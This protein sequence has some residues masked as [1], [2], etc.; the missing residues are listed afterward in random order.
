MDHPSPSPPRLHKSML[1]SNCWI[2]FWLLLPSSCNKR[3]YNHF[4]NF[5]LTIIFW[6]T[7][8]HLLNNPTLLIFLE[9]FVT[10]HTRP[11][12][13]IKIDQKIMHSN[14]PSWEKS[15][16]LILSASIFNPLLPVCQ[17]TAITKIDLRH[18]VKYLCKFLISPC[19]TFP[20]LSRTIRL[21]YQLL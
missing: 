14:L 2:H 13:P 18:I 3:M 1:W 11:I 7:S 8:L 19:M 9:N 17:T 16:P 5:F 6:E 15:F 20:L 10:H 12:S 21:W 4:F